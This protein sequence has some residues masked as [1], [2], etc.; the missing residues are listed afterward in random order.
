MSMIA[1]SR[2]GFGLDN[3]PISHVGMAHDR[4]PELDDRSAIGRL[5]TILRA[6]AS[7]AGRSCGRFVAALHDSRRKRAAVEL[8]MHRHL[9]DRRTGISFGTISPIQ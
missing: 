2:Q 5:T 8:A 1:I 9:C 6:I 3:H 4:A 7:G